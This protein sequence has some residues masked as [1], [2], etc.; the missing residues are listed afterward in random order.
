MTNKKMRAGRDDMRER[1]KKK[2]RTG[3]G[4]MAV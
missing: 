1:E 2:E 3:R 4:K